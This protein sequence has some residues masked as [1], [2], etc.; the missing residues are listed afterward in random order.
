MEMG[1]I[2]PE[3]NL[4]LLAQG[5]GQSGLTLYLS[6]LRAF[7]TFVVKMSFAMR[8]IYDE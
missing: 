1:I 2:R 6:D 7:A 8:C 4:D 5:S 3:F